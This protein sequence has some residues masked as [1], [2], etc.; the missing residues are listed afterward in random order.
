MKEKKSLSVLSL[1]FSVL[2]CLTIVKQITTLSL[3]FAVRLWL[4]KV[5]V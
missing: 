5:P 4:T 3:V 1:L 2:E